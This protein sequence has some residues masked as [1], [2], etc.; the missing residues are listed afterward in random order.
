MRNLFSIATILVICFIATGS[1]NGQL[2]CPEAY[3]LVGGKCLRLYNKKA[4]YDKAVKICSKD[5]AFLVYPRTEEEHENV[6]SWDKID[7]RGRR[8]NFWIGL[9]NGRNVGMDMV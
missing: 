7:S 9:S 8:Y 3:D 1:I 6:M 2:F 5:D 4:T